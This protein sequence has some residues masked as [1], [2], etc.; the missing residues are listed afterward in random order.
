M[1]LICRAVAEALVVHRA[2]EDTRL[3]LATRETIIQ[4]L[5]ATGLHAEIIAQNLCDALQ[6][7]IIEGAAV[8]ETAG[9]A[10]HLAQ[11]RL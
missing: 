9:L 5:I 3:H 8:A 4:D 2:Y 10:P 11:Q 1:H 7:H 6:R